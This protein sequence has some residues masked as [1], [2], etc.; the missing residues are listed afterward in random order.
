MAARVTPA[1]IVEMQRLYNQ[2]GNYAAVGRKMNR[3]G[4]TV[5]RYI[6]LKGT[7]AIVAYTFKEVVRG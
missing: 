5:A 6:K 1:E 3:S 7:P 2:L 4:S